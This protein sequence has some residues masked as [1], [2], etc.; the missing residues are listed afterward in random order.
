[1]TAAYAATVTAAT[2]SV[3]GPPG[4]D[5]VELAKLIISIF[6]IRVSDSFF[7]SFW[8]GYTVFAY[9]FSALLLFGIVYAM[10]RYEQLSDEEQQLLRDEEHAYKHAHGVIEGGSRWQGV[11][12]HVSSE[13]PNDWRLA[14]IEADIMLDE[15]LDD[16]GYVGASIGD[17]LKTA[18]PETF[19]TLN[20]AWEAHK[21]R[22][23]IAH[24]GSDFV[25]TQRL[26]DETIN[27]YARVF[28]EF[29]II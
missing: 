14:I 24:R 13:S 9:I 18:N 25:L 6:G 27:R 10:I 12:E 29:G 21:V 1:M 8:T 19:R 23:D 2:T 7:S 17:K 5:I 16:L 3:S 20:D 15:L 4:I 28:Q 11:V 26:A 22:N